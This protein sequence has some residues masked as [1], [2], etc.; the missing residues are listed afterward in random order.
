[1]RIKL[2]VLSKYFYLAFFALAF[3]IIRNVASAYPSATLNFSDI[4]PT[5][6]AIVPDVMVTVTVNT[7]TFAG[8]E[9]NTLVDWNR[10]LVG[11]WRFSANGN[12]DDSSSYANN[13]TASGT[14]WTSSGKYGGALNFNGTSDFV[15]I[16]ATSSLQ[17]TNGLTASA[18]VKTT[19]TSTGFKTIIT[20]Q[21]NYPTSGFLIS[22]SGDSGLLHVAWGIGSGSSFMSFDGNTAIN[23]GNWHLVSVTLNSGKL[24]TY[25]DG[26]ADI[27]VYCNSDPIAYVV[28]RNFTIG[29]NSDDNIEYWKGSIDDVQIYKRVLS[30]KEIKSL[31][32]GTVNRYKNTFKG[33][34]PSTYTFQAY[35]EAAGTT[36][37]HYSEYRTI[38]T[39]NPFVGGDG[40][41]STPYQVNNCSQLQAI[42]YFLNNK[43]IL[44]GNVDCSAT[45]I[46]DENDINYNENL[47][48]NGAGLEPIGISITSGFFTG[49]FNGNGYAI[50]NLNMHRSDSEYS[51]SAGLFYNAI[52]ATIKN[53]T[54]NNASVSA[55]G[56]AGIL[57]TYLQDSTVENI[58]INSSTLDEPDGCDESGGGGL[59]SY[60]SNTSIKD[61]YVKNTNV[62]STCNGGGLIATAEANTTI[63]NSYFEGNIY[64]NSGIVGGLIGSGSSITVSSSYSKG[65]V[66]S[67]SSNYAGGLIGG[68]NSSQLF[69]VYS[70]SN[71]TG[72]DKAGGL[73]GNM[74]TS[75]IENT[76]ATG[77]VSGVFYVGGLI[78]ND[79]GSAPPTVVNSYATGNVTGNDAVGGL[80]GYNAYDRVYNSFFTGKVI[81]TGGTSGG[82]IGYMFE[83][84]LNSH[85]NNLGVY[86]N[87]ANTNSYAIG[88]ESNAGAA[89]DVT[90]NETDKT[91]FYS[92]TH[93]VYDPS[94]S[95]IYPWDFTNVWKENS[96]ALPT[97]RMV[98]STV[99]SYTLTYL[100][101]TGG[102][103]SGA[104]SQTIT[105]GGNG[106]AVIA[107][108]NSGYKFV[109]WSDNTTANPRT[110]TNITTNTSYT[111]NFSKV[112]SG[113]GSYAPSAPKIVSTP[114]L[115]GSSINSGVSNVAQMAIS[116]SPDFS[117][118]SWVPY[119]ETYKTTDKV[120]YVKFM[121][122]DG[123]V[124][125]VYKVEPQITTVVGKDNDIK[126]PTVGNSPT[127]SDKY[128]F[129]NNLKSGMV[130]DDVKRLQKF[131]NEQGY[132]ITKT[133]PG[134]PGNE[135]NMFG[136]L[137][138]E[139]LIRFQKDQHITPAIGYF[140]PVTRGIIASLK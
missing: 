8:T 20:N 31:Y 129:N 44:T 42:T 125:L 103:I 110:D 109:N 86:K 69:G 51:N 126:T 92:K 18:W 25:V 95:G 14:T 64:N 131:L 133:G 105:S 49:S 33:L 97:L 24:M 3:L 91:V 54:F 87:P 55:E 127:A 76:Y 38:N 124:S 59:A 83:D 139:A 96:G 46:S 28:N 118:T 58:A 90:Y 7:S 30:S 88:S 140:G 102:T 16:P 107:V 138:R 120:I 116:T 104:T 4:T 48:N 68:L 113:G 21:W 50:N 136:R 115:V 89:I 66:I 6:G 106:S 1:M 32:N 61:S 112:S 12:F 98:S 40:T 77:N 137:T 45:K 53:V 47:Y 70:E 57:A 9:Y 43:F 35:A 84:S 11:W 29:K 36:T 27:E 119:N 123:G 63:L 60:A 130:N 2:K 93:G 114:K 13:G 41:T 39:I 65:E 37:I 71:V 108:P 100:A 111:A 99:S 75:H 81:S 19:A 62:T 85:L 15:S 132:T 134:S 74:Q 26:V 128:Q 121:S 34:L 72:N 101:S 79:Y 56:D 122:N 80:I 67:G 117:N 82:L 94:S 23:D 22:M 73:I 135:T 10:T 17:I 5:D 52:G 78:G